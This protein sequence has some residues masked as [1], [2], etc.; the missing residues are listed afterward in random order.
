MP[1]NSEG[2]PHFD[3][4]VVG[5]GI[6]GGWAAKELTERGLKVL[7]L[8]RG[9][10]VVHRHDY[11]TEGKAAWELPYRGQVPEE[12]GARDHA[13]QKKCYAFTGYTEHFFINDR[14]NPYAT[15]ADAPFDWIRGDQLG[16]RSLLWQRQC[17]RLSDLDFEANRRDGHGVDWPIRYKDI[18]PWYDHVERFA[19]ISGSLEGLPQLP[20]GQFQPPYPL[21]CVETE[22]GQRIARQFPERRLIIGRTAHL[23]EPTDEQR[24]LGR[25]RCMNRNECQRGCSFGAYFSSLS[26]TLPAAERTGNLTTVTDA[27]VES[28][29]YD[30]ASGRATGVR[31]IDRRTRARRFYGARIV[32]LCASTLGTAQIM[33]NSVS[34]RFPNGI[35]NASGTL[36]RYLMD[37]LGGIAS[38]GVVPGFLDR[39]DS[40][41]RPT[42]C[43]IPRYANVTIQD[44]RF[45]RGYA[46]QCGAERPGWTRG[47][48]VPGIG[49]ALKERLRDPGPWT[50]SVSGFGEMLP[51]A[52][53]RV[54]L[55]EK[56][57]DRWGI[58]LLNIDCRHRENDLA[59]MAA[60]ADDAE[61]M[62]AAVGLEDIRTY[63]GGAA[64]GLLVHEMGT[65][66]MGRD[67]A[68]SVL[69]GH[70]QAHD[71]P[72]LFVT[73][74]AAMASSAC[75]NPSL[76]YMAF[77]ARAASTAAAMLKAGTL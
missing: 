21:N 40:G 75:Q 71:V 11:P 34:E 8:E 53:N 52:R 49:T 60:I 35:A 42:R 54:W 67:P 2:T 72:N 5:S 3:A 69:N 13:V 47:P 76:T 23:T 1:T 73:D 16:G 55:D 7:V 59:M 18:A 17:Y 74:G 30:E 27:I 44:E 26:A 15:P 32:F 56:K 9:R 66:R 29:A 58:P 28:V 63:R 19:G 12:R 41:R 68:T 6:S 65:A 25:A 39:Y 51:D 37:H 24:A 4:I 20:D 38:V 45:V 22:V 70:S 10:E 46:Y 61:A 14:E 48:G 33:L 62:L 31:I 43:Y 50:F 64:P 36:G 57:T 77:T